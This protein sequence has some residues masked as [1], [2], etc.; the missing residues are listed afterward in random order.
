M[1]KEDSIRF[2]FAV[3][4][5]VMTMISLIYRNFFYFEIFLAA[6]LGIAFFRQSKGIVVMCVGLFIYV[7]SIFEYWSIIP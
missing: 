3:F 4:F 7:M 2:S 5:L 6:A 1:E